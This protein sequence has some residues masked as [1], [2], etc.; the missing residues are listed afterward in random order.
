MPALFGVLLKIVLLLR[1]I[2]ILFPNI[3]NIH[4]EHLEAFL[5]HHLQS[6]AKIL[7]PVDKRMSLTKMKAD[8]LHI[9]N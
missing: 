6:K 2:H 1:V 4:P 8:V 5:Y 7:Q 3:P 9:L